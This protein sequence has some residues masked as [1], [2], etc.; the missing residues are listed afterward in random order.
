[1]AEPQVIGVGESES[2]Y[3]FEVKGQKNID[4]SRQE[5]STI[6]DCHIVGRWVI[7]VKESESGYRLG[8]KGQT[9]IENFG[10]KGQKNISLSFQV[11]EQENPKISFQ[12]QKKHFFADFRAQKLKEVLLGSKEHFLWLSFWDRKS[13]SR[14]LESKKHIFSRFLTSRVRKSYLVVNKF[15]RK[16][17]K[18]LCCYCPIPW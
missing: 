4:T 7:E 2:G 18:V 14:L 8:V 15:S 1:M 5:F 16:N 17:T 9:N 3:R 6:D 10:V 13:K 11:F 12:S